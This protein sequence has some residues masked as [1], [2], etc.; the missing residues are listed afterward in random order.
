[1]CP[2]PRGQ[3]CLLDPDGLSLQLDGLQQEA[4]AWQPLRRHLGVPP[5]GADERQPLALCC[6]PGGQPWKT[7]VVP[8][9]PRYRRGR[10]KAPQ[11]Q[12]T[13]GTPTSRQPSWIKATAH[14]FPV[15]QAAVTE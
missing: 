3:P 10:T 15:N 14:F 5:L 9:S 4:E 11:L 12:E 1:M 2:A 13:P 6:V 8:E 7:E